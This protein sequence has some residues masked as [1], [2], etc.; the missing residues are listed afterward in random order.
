MT[1]PTL[2]IPEPELSLMEEVALLPKADQEEAIRQIAPMVD[3]MADLRYMW[4]LWARPSQLPPEGEWFTWLIRK[5]RGAGKTRTGAEWVIQRAKDGHGPIALVGQTKA[6]VRDTMVELGESSIMKV[7]EPSFMPHYEPSKRR[8]TWPNGVT[9]TVFS[10]DEPD[11][12]RGPQHATIWSDELCKWKYPEDAYSNAVLGLRIGEDPKH[13]I[14]TTPRPIPIIKQI[15]SD[16][17][18]VDVTG[19]TF[20]NIA[21]LSPIFIQQILRMYDGTRLGLQEIYGLILEDTEGALWTLSNIEENRVR[22]V[23]DLV[24]VAVGVDPKAKSE[25]DSETGIVV[26]GVDRNREGYVLEDYSLNGR[27]ADWANQIVKAFNVHKADVI[28][29]EIN[30]GGDMVEH[31]IQTVRDEEDRPIGYHLPIYT[32][33]ASRGKRT[34]AEPISFLYEQGR[35]H[36]VGKMGKLEDQMTTWVPDESPSPDRV[37][38]LVW[39]LS[40]LMIPQRKKASTKRRRRASA[41]RRVKRVA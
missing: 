41:R 36:H 12:L 23:P 34:R 16:P 18:T 39:G 8:L 9:A 1:T 19:S 14:T 38:A 25:A 7:S 26:V 31:T 32:V 30:N 2:E 22:E 37:D 28:V 40:A 20:E 15:V 10:G 35:I 21:N 17:M 5:G 24:R 29:A 3:D 4:P 27:P 11:Q 13:L 33:H 6:D